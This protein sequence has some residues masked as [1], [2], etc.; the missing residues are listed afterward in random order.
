MLVFPSLSKACDA[1]AVFSYNTINQRSY[2]AGF[3]NYRAMSGYKSFKTGSFFPQKSDY[4]KGKTSHTLENTFLYDKHEYDYEIFE[5]LDFQ[6]NIQLNEDFNLFFQQG[7]QWMRLNYERVYFSGS[8]IP[9]NYVFETKGNSDFI[10]GAIRFDQ[11]IKEKGNRQIKYGLLLNMP[12]GNNSLKANGY[13]MHPVNQPAYGAFG[14]NL[15]GAYNY[16]SDMGLSLTSQFN[17]QYFGVSEFFEDAY[18][19]GPRANADIN[20]KYI[21]D[22]G[23]WYFVPYIGCNTFG[24]LKD[25][26]NGVIES[27]TGGIVTMGNLG[28]EVSYKNVTF[29]S[30][31]QLPL[32]QNVIDNQ[33]FNSGRARIGFIYN[34]IQ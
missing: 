2:A 13:L 9:E 7:Y 14:L 29:H 31:I 27:E 11:K 30:Q 5:S 28:M 8:G 32:F 6:V 12:T 3:Y 22:A 16:F 21:A 23:Y 24:T 20:I 4:Q 15:L 34:F 10:I 19:H 18:Q 26:M 33:I 25:K 1:C 17:V